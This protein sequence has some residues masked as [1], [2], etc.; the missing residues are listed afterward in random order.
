VIGRTHQ[1]KDAAE[2]AEQKRGK[3]CL[4]KKKKGEAKATAQGKEQVASRTVKEQKRIGLILH[5]SCPVNL[6][7]DFNNVFFFYSLGDFE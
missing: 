5:F 7:R 4:K 6:S 2:P 3:G 1:T